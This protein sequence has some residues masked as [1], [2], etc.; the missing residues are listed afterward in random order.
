MSRLRSLIGNRVTEKDVRD[1]LTDRGLSGSTARF[2]Y[3]KLVA[4]ERPG[5]I[6]I[7]AFRV[8]TCDISGA[9][10]TF[11]GVVRDDERNRTEIRLEDTAE[12]QEKVIHSWSK[13]L[14]TL[15]RKPL[16]KLQWTLLALFAGVLATALVGVVMS[17]ANGTAG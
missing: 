17:A 7:F 16:N 10:R 6:Q 14:I 1:F 13:D 8:A 3:L 4:I 5:W 12:A 15:R 9:K 2:D 11:F